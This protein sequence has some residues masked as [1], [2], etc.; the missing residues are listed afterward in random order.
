MQRA[1]TNILSADVS[2]TAAFYEAVLGMHRHYESDWFII[3]S[4]AEMPGLEFGILKRDSEIVP[5][6]LRAAP[7]G[8]LVT[9][10]VADCDAAHAAALAAGAEIVT[11]PTDMAY[12]QRRMLLRDPDGTAVD[13]SAPTAPVTGIA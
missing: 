4:H 9:F 8:V 13:I 11:P 6:A 3:L 2:R 10:V 7:A 1:F 5:A 12:G